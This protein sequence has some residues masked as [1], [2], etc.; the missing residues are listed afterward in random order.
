MLQRMTSTCFHPSSF[1]PRTVFG[2]LFGALVMMNGLAFSQDSQYE[3]MFNGKD[4]SGWKGIDKFWSV[5]DGKIV[6]KTTKENP[7]KGNTFL[8]W[9]GDDAG[10]FDFRCKV[11]FSGNNTGV[12]YRSK[13]ANAEKFVLHGNQAD[14]HPN[15]KYFGMLYGEGTRGITATRGQ[16]VVISADK[17]KKV[18]GKVGNDDKL[19]DDEWNELRIVAVG[20][21][22]IH[23]VNGVTTV[24]ITDDHPD[25][26]V[27]GAIGLQ[28]HAGGA[29]TVAFQDLKIKRLG[30]AEGK[31]LIQSLEEDGKPKTK[32][33]IPALQKSIEDP[34]TGLNL[35]PGFA[36]EL[37]YKVDKEKYGSW[38]SMDFDDQNRLVVS[39]QGNKGVFRIDLPEIGGTFSEHDITKLDLKNSVHGFLYA[40][41]HLYTIRFGSLSRAPVLANGELGPE[42]VISEL[43][44]RG[45]HGPHSMIV[46]PDGKSLYVIGGN[47]TTP[48]EHQN[49]RIQENMQND[50]LLKHYTFGHNAGGK[51]P[52]GFVMKYS[53]DGK[54]R[55]LLCMGYRNPVDFALNRQGELFVYD[56]DMEYDIASPWYRPTRINHGVSGAENG[57]RAT[58]QKWRKYF[59]DTVGSVVDIGPGSPTGV[60]PGTN[61]KFPT[62]YRDALFVCDWTFATMYSIHLTPNGSSYTAEKREF[63]S[64]TNGP[65]SLTDV[66]IG[67]D[68]HMYFCVG[69]RGGQ[70]Y[71]YRVYYKGT[72]STK[73]SELDNTGAEARATRHMLE[74]F[75]GHAD[76]KAISTVWP[77]LS[78]DDYHLR[79]AARIAIEWQDTAT[80]A[81]KA[82]NETNDLAAIHA[83]LGLCRRDLAGSLPAILN[84]LNAVDFNALDKTGKLALLRTYA[85]AMSRQGMPT[86]DLQKAAGDKLDAHFPAK[87]DNLNEELC[88]VL[89]YLEHP[90]VVAKTVALMKITETKA[91]EFDAEIMKR[92]DR[93]GPSILNSMKS[94]PNTL[95][96]HYLFCLKDVKA[97]W[98]MEDRKFYFNW[99]KDLVSRSGGNQY[100]DFLRNIRETAIEGVPAKERLALQH[101]LG[102]IKT[103][104]LATLPKATGPGVEWTVDAALK[105][106]NDKPLVGRDLANGKK[107]FKAGQCIACHH[108]GNEGGGVGPDLT[109]LAKRS[110]YKSILE[111][112]ITPSLVV[113]DQFEQHIFQ[114]E[115]GQL[116]VGRIASEDDDE[117]ALM[118]SGL[119]PTKL[120]KIKLSDID[121]RKVSK[122]SMMPTETI[123]AMNADEL[124]DLIAYFVSQGNGRHA[125]YKKGKGKRAKGAK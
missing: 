121:A 42:E 98:S 112:I 37:I 90:S 93:Y 117:L 74:S 102:D 108:F 13:I 75:H 68:G 103:I 95:N 58:T 91:S 44:G 100:A 105:M 22:L 46:S 29:M 56:A 45:E 115:D 109:N 113:S 41:D 86:P 8:I 39:D 99:V 3:N 61:A 70:S 88:R 118:K 96:M 65:L 17:K 60:I 101:L 107:M 53:P 18:V 104:D 120:T 124:K 43:H 97:G 4:L 11:K 71:L 94:A 123:N 67:K 34:A 92:S 116:V 27:T 83:L 6:G 63:V 40:F 19:V 81:E 72:D 30:A 79:Y 14:L 1:F 77:Y 64:N 51:A 84:R 47:M 52:A 66:Q 24:D 12:Q 2:C 114:L 50:V 59:P 54:Q 69:G 85:V 122:V 73:L 16:R 55:E 31:R 26:K 36:A 106:L 35:Q 62:H 119:E 78:S 25:A 125:V 7:T 111:S 20:N 5:E 15:P 82:C 21:R 32:K 48:P 23:Q 110:D 33:S 38:I 87:D 76:P 28:L 57:W 80:W 10:D 9:Q 89:S 49:S